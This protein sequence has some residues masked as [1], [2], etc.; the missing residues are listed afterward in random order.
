MWGIVERMRAHQPR[1]TMLHG[2]ILNGGNLRS[3][4]PSQKGSGRSAD[5]MHCLLITGRR[6][7]PSHPGKNGPE[8]RLG[9]GV[10]STTTPKPYK[11][12]NQVPYP[13]PSAP[14]MPE[15]AMRFEMTLFPKFPRPTRGGKLPDPPLGNKDR[16]KYT[17]S[18]V[19]AR[20]FRFFNCTFFRPDQVPSCAIKPNPFITQ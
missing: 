15:G 13:P 19:D 14:E 11:P 7:L 6:A 9:R 10:R 5:A 16:L 3:E 18:C 2:S 12:M 17:C 1:R 8:H 20:V 4:S